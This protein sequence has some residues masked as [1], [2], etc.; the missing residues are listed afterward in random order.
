M[1]VGNFWRTICIHVKLL[2]RKNLAKISAYAKYIFGVSV[3]KILVSK[4]L[5]NGSRFAK[6][7]NFFPA[8]IFPC[9]RYMV[10]NNRLDL[11]P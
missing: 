4:I 9:T 8:K 1:Y 11:F 5:A 3:K 6:F 2:V 10:D 7:T